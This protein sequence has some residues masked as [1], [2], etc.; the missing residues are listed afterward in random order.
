MPGTSRWSLVVGR[1]PITYA[2]RYWQNCQL[3]LHQSKDFAD[4]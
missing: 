4:D 3:C 1:W 2:K